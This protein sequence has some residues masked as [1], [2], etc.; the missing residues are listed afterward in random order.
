MIHAYYTLCPFAPDGSGRILAAAADLGGHGDDGRA[1]GPHGAHGDKA[2]DSGRH[3]VGGPAERLSGDAARG[4]VVILDREGA[5]LDRFGGNPVSPSFWHTGFWQSW[6]PDARFVY[7][8]SATLKSP[9]IVRRELATGNELSV[10]GDM[11]GIPPSGEPGLSCS[12]GLLY[13]AGYGTGRYAPQEA[14]VPFQAREDHGIS[15][16]VFDPQPSSRLVL[17]TAEILERHP[18]RDRLL[19]ADREMRERH[20]AGDGLTLMTYCVRWNNRGDQF[21]FY[22]GNHNVV[23]ERGEPRI[24]SV[25]TTDRSLRDIRLA[26]DLSFGRRG[27]HWAWH[28]DNKRLV[29]YGPRPEDPSKACLMVVDADGGNPSVISDHA[30]GGHPSVHPVDHDLYLTDDGRRNPG[31]IELI[32]GRTGK[33]VRRWG[34]PRVYGDTEP[35]GRNPYRVCHHPVFDREGRTI[36]ANV[37]PG[38][39]AGLAAIT[40]ISGPG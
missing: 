37:L 39:D 24:G 4:E 32:E 12:H 27:V 2:H 7:Y 31:F 1:N 29:G 22:F 13:A 34:L 35:S 11:E 36:L 26:V 8:Q 40:A 21:L 18:Q 10:A 3:R 25:F 28:P 20:G 38:R 23:R 33:T 5:V 17:T 30:T 15:E 6:G 16:V 9:R 14:P 19:E